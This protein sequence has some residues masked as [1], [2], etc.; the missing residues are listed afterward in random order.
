M[1]KKS[2]T[3]AAQAVTDKFFTKTEDQQEG[4]LDDAQAAQE[5]R[6]DVRTGES[7][8]RTKDAQKG[9]QAAQMRR[10]RNKGKNG[11]D[12][13]VFSFR[14]WADEVESWRLYAQVKG[15]KV[16]DLGAAA[17]REYIKRHPV[18]DEERQYQEAALLLKS[19]N[20]KA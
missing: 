10:E 1:N 19:R 6:Q 4:V 9:A 3:A 12:V 13:K 18:T 17:M 2:L 16:D 8:G 11:D 15:V 5:G 20:Q 14:S 7:S